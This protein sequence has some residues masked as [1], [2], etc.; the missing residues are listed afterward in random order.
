LYPRNDLNFY[1]GEKAIRGEQV[2][3]FVVIDAAARRLSLQRLGADSVDQ[4]AE[5]QSERSVKHC[6]SFEIR[7]VSEQ[8]SKSMLRLSGA[9]AS[10]GHFENCHT[11]ISLSAS[12]STTHAFADRTLS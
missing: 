8:R 1:P 3:L 6:A 9:K 12:S 11:I 4:C 7:R 5:Q 10:L 2:E